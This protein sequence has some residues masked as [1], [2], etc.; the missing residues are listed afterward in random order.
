MDAM[1]SQITRLTI[2]YST[3]YSG[4]DQIKHQSF[5]SQAFVREIHRFT[6]ESP[7]QMTSNVENV[8]IWWR[9]HVMILHTEAMTLDSQNHCC[10]FFS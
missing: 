10:R 9:H 3:V 1:T 2:A 6:G 5:A 8:S 4:K 7:A